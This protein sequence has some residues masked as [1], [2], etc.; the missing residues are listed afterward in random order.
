MGKIKLQ[1]LVI[2]CDRPQPVYGPGEIISGNCVITL[3][4]ELNLSQLELKLEG[5]AEVKWTESY[6]RY[7]N[8]YHAIHPFIEIIYFPSSGKKFLKI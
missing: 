6:G 8:T 1:S 3:N 4:G 7:T 5:C 2:V